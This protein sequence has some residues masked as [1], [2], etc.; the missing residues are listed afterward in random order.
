MEP[1]NKSYR[2]R[3]GTRGCTG[4][5]GLER[6]ACAE[7]P[8]ALR[9]ALAVAA[10]E[11]PRGGRRGRDSLHSEHSLCFPFHAK[12]LASQCF[13]ELFS[14]PALTQMLPATV[15]NCSLLLLTSGAVTAC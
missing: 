12:Y 5:G 11:Q 1:G 3:F 15:Q 4:R 7:Q 6:R 13:P 14:V 8:W 9:A 10:S 2:Q